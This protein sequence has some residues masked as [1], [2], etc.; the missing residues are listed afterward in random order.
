MPHCWT[1]TG[2]QMTATGISLMHAGPHRAAL[3]PRIDHGARRPPAAPRRRARSWRPPAPTLPCGRIS[4]GVFVMPARRPAT[5]QR[6]GAGSPPERSTRKSR[7]S[8]PLQRNGRAAWSSSSARSDDIT[9]SGLLSDHA[10]R[11][12]R[13]CAAGPVH[14]YVWLH[15]LIHK[16]KPQGRPLARIPRRRCM[17]A[18]C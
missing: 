3:H 9:G 11:G 18:A 15:A 10:Q 14:G 16:A 1:E 13:R 8:P 5:R 12:R 17:H 4:D 7:K 6:P 2:S